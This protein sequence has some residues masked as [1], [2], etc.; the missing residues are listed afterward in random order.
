[1]LLQNLLR[2]DLHLPIHHLGGL[3]TASVPENL[4]RAPLHHFR[5]LFF[6]LNSSN[7]SA[8]FIQHEGVAVVVDAELAS[9]L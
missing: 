4:P 7:S 6:G 9:L 8:R 2:G 5:K 3:I 1:M